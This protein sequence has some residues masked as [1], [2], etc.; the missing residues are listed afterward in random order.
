MHRAE[1][2]ARVEQALEL[3]SRNYNC[4]QAVACACADLVGINESTAF[5]MTEGLGGGMGGYTE[6]CGAISG[7]C[8]I[9]GFKTSEGP[10]NPT[11]KHATY[12]QVRQLVDRFREKNSS[13]L[14]CEI[15]G[16]TG[17]PVLRTCPGCIEDC[18]R[19]TL[20]ILQ[21]SPTG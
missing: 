10:H 11:T 12:A 2:E 20:E 17:D 9:I 6:T 18:V 1:I 13:T 14:C 5:K 15:K 19:M 8:A 7:G 16:L 21:D 4:A 3:H